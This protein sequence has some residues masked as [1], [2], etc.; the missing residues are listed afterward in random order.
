MKL[1]EGREIMWIFYVIGIVIVV[2][3]VLLF[4]NAS[5]KDKAEEAQKKTS[6]VIHSTG[7]LSVDPT[8]GAQ[9]ITAQVAIP[10]LELKPSSTPRLTLGLGALML[11]VGPLFPW[12][13]MYNAFIGSQTLTGIEGDGIFQLILGAILF[14]V[15]I[16]YKGKAGKTYSIPAGIIAITAIVLSFILFFNM[17]TAVADAEILNARLGPGLYIGIIGSFIAA[18]GSFVKA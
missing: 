1:H 11:M 16:F 14:L 2:G 10:T 3:F 9:S 7:T 15:A 8:T 4:I 12:V 5:K 18:I 13:S 17:R 6:E